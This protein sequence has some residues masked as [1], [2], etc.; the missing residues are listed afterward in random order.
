MSLRESEASEAISQDYERRNCRAPS[1]RSQRQ[2]AITTQSSERREEGSGR[3]MNS[4]ET[5]HGQ[6]I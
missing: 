1:G 3:K 4:T 5:P 2:R 6:D